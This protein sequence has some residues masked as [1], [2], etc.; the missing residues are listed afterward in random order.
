[1]L[2]LPGANVKNGATN[3]V[4]YLKV[5][6]SVVLYLPDHLGIFFP[7]IETF[8]I[9]HAKLREI[10]QKDFKHFSKLERFYGEGN[11]IQVLEKE[12]FKFNPNLKSISFKHNHLKH[13]DPNVFDNLNSLEFLSITI[14]PCLMQSSKNFRHVQQVIEEL[15][16]NCKPRVDGN[17]DWKF[18]DDQEV[19][20]CGTDNRN[21]GLLIVLNFVLLI[22]IICIGVF[23][24]M[25]KKVTVGELRESVFYGRF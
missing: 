3:E 7:S 1:M 11:D 20:E 14:N 13:V 10:H 5:E 19:V 12:L 23:L 16:E 17:S 22:F 2:F 6:E 15:K 4:K 24:M 18:G 8:R 9:E 21:C 25:K